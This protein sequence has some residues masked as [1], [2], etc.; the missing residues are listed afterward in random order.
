LKMLVLSDPP[1]TET[2]VASSASDLWGEISPDGRWLAYQSSESGA[3]EI[4][5][6]PFPDVNTGQKQ[7]STNG[8]SRPRWARNS[9]ELFYLDS[10]GRL[11]SVRVQPSV[12]KTFAHGR[13]ETVLAQSYFSDLGASYDVGP[14]GRFLM[15]KESG[16]DRLRV[17]VVLKWTEE[18]K[19]LSPR[20]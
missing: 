4:I 17:N 20:K 11:T 15:I 14:D 12:D 9:G 19:K 3:F 7:V 16:S 6:R 13:P 18:L 10:K 2:L 8:G 1:R 5:V